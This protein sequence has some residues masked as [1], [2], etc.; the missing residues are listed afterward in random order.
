MDWYKIE[1]VINLQQLKLEQARHLFYEEL[2]DNHNRSIRTLM[3]RHGLGL[4]SKPYP[5]FLKSYVNSWLRQM[6]EIIA[7]HSAISHHGGSGA[8]YVML[9]KNQNEKAQNRELHRKK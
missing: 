3:V 9:K 8:T 5:A 1:S 6:P 4:Y 2:I 7:F